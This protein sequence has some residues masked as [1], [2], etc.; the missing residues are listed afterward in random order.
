MVVVHAPENA[1]LLDGEHPGVPP[2]P[3]PGMTPTPRMHDMFNGPSDWH[4]DIASIRHGNAWLV[5]AGGSALQQRAEVLRHL[6]PTIRI[7]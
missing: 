3:I 4:G 1:I 6:T 7:R 2:A 5:V